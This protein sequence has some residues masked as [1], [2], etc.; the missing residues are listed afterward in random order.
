VSTGHLHLDLRIS[1]QKEKP[2]IAEVISGF[3][4]VMAIMDTIYGDNF[5]NAPVLRNLHLDTNF[6]TLYR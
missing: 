5:T 6:C 1:T 3:W 2:E 4:G